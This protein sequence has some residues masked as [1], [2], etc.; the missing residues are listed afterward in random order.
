MRSIDDEG[1]DA[2]VFADTQT[3]AKRRAFG[4]PGFEDSDYTS[5]RAV[6][7]PR[8]DGREANP[9]TTRELV[10]MCGWRTRCANCGEDISHD[11]AGAWRADAA[12]CVGCLLDEV[13]RLNLVEPPG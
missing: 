6:R 3:G 12:T 7:A 1:P 11:Q 4:S 10:T 5:L 9:P 2:I 13:E 8:H